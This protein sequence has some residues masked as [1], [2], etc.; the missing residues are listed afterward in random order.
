MDAGKLENGVGGVIPDPWR[1]DVFNSAR[2]FNDRVGSYARGIF[3][4]S[5]IMGLMVFASMLLLGVLVS[6]VFFEY[7]I[8]L[9]IIAAIMEVLPM[10][11]IFIALVPALLVAASIGPQAVVAVLIVYLILSQVEGSVVT[12]KVQSS[13]V[14]LHPAL[15]MMVILLGFHIGGIVVAL[16]SIPFIAAGRDIV[17]YLYQRLADVPPSPDEAIA[18]FIQPRQPIRLR[19]AKAP[20]PAESQT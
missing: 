16:I 18:S 14:E 10:I 9:A 11:G 20:E 6:P 4:E 5:V 13:A 7:A 3:M 17:S 19:R 2:I 8:F 15:V 1:P 12:P